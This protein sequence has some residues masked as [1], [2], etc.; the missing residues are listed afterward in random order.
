MSDYFDFIKSNTFRSEHSIGEELGDEEELKEIVKSV[1]NE[2]VEPIAV[3]DE[4]EALDKFKRLNLFFEKDEVRAFFAFI[5]WHIKV[6]ILF[7]RS[8][9]QM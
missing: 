2:S 6:T 4:N 7:Y 3:D 9:Q 8:I 5:I 1:D